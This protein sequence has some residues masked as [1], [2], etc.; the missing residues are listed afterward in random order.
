MTYIPLPLEGLL[1]IWKKCYAQNVDKREKLNL[2]D[3]IIS[4]REIIR[5]DGKEFIQLS[6][7][8]IEWL[9]NLYEKP[10]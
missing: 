10:F 1:K 5:R 7:V 6:K 3:S 2:L 4:K 8:E 9:K